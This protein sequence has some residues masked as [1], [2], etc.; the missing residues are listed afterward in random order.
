MFLKERFENKIEPL[1]V[2]AIRVVSVCP[3]P[4][5]IQLPVASCQTRI[6][7][8]FIGSPKTRKTLARNILVKQKWSYSVAV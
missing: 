3:Y 1:K 6:T 2:P 4:S 7:S 5:L 8:S